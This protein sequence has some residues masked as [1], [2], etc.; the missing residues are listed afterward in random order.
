M[1]SSKASIRRLPLVSRP[2]AICH[3]RPS[4]PPPPVTTPSSI[5]AAGTGDHVPRILQPRRPQGEP[6]PS[7]TLTLTYPTS[8]HFH[9]DLIALRDTIC[10]IRTSISRG[11]VTRHLILTCG[12]VVAIPFCAHG[13][14]RCMSARI[15]GSFLAFHVTVSV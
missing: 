1:S 4:P 3:L 10:L 12:P 6:P 13:R 2:F 11:G 7:R 15:D 8:F 9:L 5:S 14:I